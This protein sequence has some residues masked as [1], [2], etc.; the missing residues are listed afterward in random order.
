MNWRML[1]VSLGLAVGFAAHVST[2]SAS[3]NGN[4]SH[5]AIHSI[6][7]KVIGCVANGT[8]PGQYRLTNAFLSGDG[9]PSRAGTPG[10]EGSGQDLSFEN[11]P[12]F[13]LIGSRLAAHLGHKVEVIG[14]TSDTKM[15]HSE[16]FH[17][18]IGSSTQDKATLTVSSVTL[19]G[20]AC[21]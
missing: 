8:E 10:R 11:S 15:N 7:V 19:I 14:I 2:Q 3:A 1:V 18:A 21:L 17:W 13:D 16:A 12:S 20:A 6:Q 9:V 5:E 4:A